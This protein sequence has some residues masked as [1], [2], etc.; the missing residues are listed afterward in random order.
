MCIRDRNSPLPAEVNRGVA[1]N[2]AEHGRDLGTRFGLSLRDL[3]NVPPVGGNMPANGVNYSVS[4]RKSLVITYIDPM[5]Y[6]NGRRHHTN[7]YEHMRAG[8]NSML[9]VRRGQTFDVK[10]TLDRDYAPQVDAV[11]L[12]FRLAG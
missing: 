6:E 8:D 10:L 11:S 3:L 1:T 9:I 2:G 12:V 5:V 7:Y 4:R